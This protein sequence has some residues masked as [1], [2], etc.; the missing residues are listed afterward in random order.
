MNYYL[1]ETEW[2]SFRKKI[3]KDLL[4][5]LVFFF[6]V[7][8]LSPTFSFSFP[9]QHGVGNGC[10][11]A[12]L[13]L[14][15]PSLSRLYCLGALHRGQML[16]VTLPQF[17]LPFLTH[18][19]PNSLRPLASLCLPHPVPPR[20]FQHNPTPPPPPCLPSQAGA[21]N[22]PCFPPLS[23]RYLLSSRPIMALGHLLLH[24]KAAF[25][26]LTCVLVPI[27]PEIPSHFFKQH[28]K[29]EGLSPQYR[30]AAGDSSVIGVL[31]ENRK[32]LLLPQRH[33]RT[34]NF[35]WTTQQIEISRF[36]AQNESGDIWASS[37]E[38]AP[39]RGGR[40]VSY[41]SLSFHMDTPDWPVR[42]AACVN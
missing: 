41:L 29:T 37:L 30:K 25:S 7:Q 24:S 9:W 31:Q 19:L 36:P 20:P 15:A 34:A 35:Y 38:P 14:A 27:S 1:R 17:V 18:R 40:V 10:D 3:L 2:P 12:A 39:S 22:S 23:P 5:I 4:I 26:A 11:I 13:P 6:F 42:W 33:S 28:W 8:T 32:M 21:L 16:S